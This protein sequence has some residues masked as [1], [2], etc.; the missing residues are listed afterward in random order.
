ML[1]VPM[2]TP[3]SAQH[4]AVEVALSSDWVHWGSQGPV[5]PSKLAIEL[6]KPGNFKMA[7]GYRQ[8][9]GGLREELN[10]QLAAWLL[11]QFQAAPHR[12]M[13]PPIHDDVGELLALFCVLA[14]SALLPLQTWLAGIP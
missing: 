8:A 5:V 12:L 2:L 1:G 6:K 14:L 4:F 3:C 11:P 7:Q 13:G 9:G 10:I